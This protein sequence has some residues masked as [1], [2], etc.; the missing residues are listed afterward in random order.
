MVKMKCKCGKEYEA[1]TADLKRGWGQ[2][3]SKKCAAKY[4]NV[5]CPTEAS[6]RYG[7]RYR[8]YNTD[9][10]KRRFV[11]REESAVDAKW[12]IHEEAQIEASLDY[13]SECGDK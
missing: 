8:K 4:R 3:C 1:R 10:K 2:Y 13:L 5:N 6:L 11:Q 12:R 9:S 7:N